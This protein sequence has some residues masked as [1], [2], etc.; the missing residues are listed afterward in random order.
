ML[1]MK[2]ISGWA[3]TPRATVSTEKIASGS[4]ISQLGSWNWALA[5]LAA[6]PPENQPRTLRDNI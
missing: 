1:W 3:Y 6:T 5:S 4:S 2:V